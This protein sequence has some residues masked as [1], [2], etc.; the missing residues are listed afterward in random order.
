M[1]SPEEDPPHSFNM[2]RFSKWSGFIALLWLLFTSVLLV[3]PTHSDPVL[4]ITPDNFNFTGVITFGAEIL[5][6]F[7]WFSIRDKYAGPE[8]LPLAE[9]KS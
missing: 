8:P 6:I 5:A 3:T 7:Y 4:G 2:H 1:V 9:A